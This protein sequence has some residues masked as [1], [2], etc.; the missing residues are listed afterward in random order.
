ML[1]RNAKDWTPMDCAAHGG[2]D[3]LVKLLIEAEAELEPEDR[4]GVSVYKVSHSVKFETLCITA[5]K[6]GS[7]KYQAILN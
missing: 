4:G 3:Y 6:P 1:C 7:I 5:F 2:W